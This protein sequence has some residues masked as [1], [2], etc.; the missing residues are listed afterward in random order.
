MSHAKQLHHQGYFDDY[1]KIINRSG[2]PGNVKSALSQ[3]VHHAVIATVQSVIEQALEEELT[4][5]LGC[6]RYEHLPWGRDP[7]QTRSGSYRRELFTPHGCIPALRVPKLR[8]GNGAL[9][10]QTIERYERCWGPLLDQQVMGYCLGRSLRDLHESM[11]LTL[12]EV[13]SVSS[14]NRIVLGMAKQVD[15]FKTTPLEDPPPIL[16]VDGMWVKIASPTGEIVEDAQGRRRAAKR[17]QKRVVLSALGVWPD[18]HW[19]IVYWQVASGENQP[20]WAAFFQALAAK[21]MTEKTTELVASDGATGLE[22]ALAEHLRGVPH[23]RCIFHKIKNIADHLVFHELEVDDDL[24]EAKAVRKAKQARKKAMLADAGQ[25]YAS[26]GE[27]DIRAQAAAFRKKWEVREPKAVANFFTDFDKTLAYL[28]VDFP[29]SLLPLI[30]TTNLL[31][32]FHKEV[33]RKQCD[34]GMFQSERGCEVLWYLISTRE[35]AKQL[36]ALKGQS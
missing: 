22:N 33:R 19:E 8:R 2:L 10:W 13:L 28:Q 31:E 3:Q 20:A 27:G 32:R 36:A 18:G 14:C 24:D 11:R 17:Q 12:G 5:Y 34:I 23:Q 4:T 26:D 6:A 1:L 21:G 7:E 16:L 25:M 35:S 15:A 29:R 9:T 30:R